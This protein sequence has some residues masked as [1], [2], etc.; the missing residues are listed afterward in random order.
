M[1]IRKPLL[2]LLLCLYLQSLLRFLLLPTLRFR[3]FH[4][5]Q[6]YAES[7]NGRKSLHHITISIDKEFDFDATIE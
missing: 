5:G 4:A 2:L 3:R 6:K 7:Y 1:T